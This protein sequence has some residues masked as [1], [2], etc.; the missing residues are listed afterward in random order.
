MA[1]VFPAYT[2]NARRGVP[3]VSPQS[4]SFKQPEKNQKCSNENALPFYTCWL[5]RSHR[6]PSEAKCVSMSS[7]AGDCT[8]H[9]KLHG[10]VSSG[11]HFAPG[12]ESHAHL[13]LYSSPPRAI[14]PLS[15]TLIPLTT[16]NS[17]LLPSQVRDSHEP[18]SSA[19]D[20]YGGQGQPVCQLSKL[21]AFIW[22]HW[23]AQVQ[24]RSVSYALKH[25]S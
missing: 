6:E 9:T 14:T 19:A 11:A 13:Q 2:A 20:A 25:P 5:P 15:F 10:T 3:A 24:G 8:V 21:L 1:D 16:H 17:T 23:P 4:H 7:N 12:T 22:A 18:Y